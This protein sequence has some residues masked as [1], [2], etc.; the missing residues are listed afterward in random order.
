MKPSMFREIV[1]FI[2]M[3]GIGRLRPGLRPK[4]EMVIPLIVISDWLD[5]DELIYE[6]YLRKGVGKVGDPLL[7]RTIKR[8]YLRYSRGRLTNYLCTEAVLSFR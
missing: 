6:V 3:E 2:P 8:P 1:D 7:V 5:Y 4:G